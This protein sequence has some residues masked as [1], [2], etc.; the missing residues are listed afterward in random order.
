MPPDP[1]NRHAIESVDP[2]AI[3][4]IDPH[5]IDSLDP[6]AIDSIDRQTPSDTITSG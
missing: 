1:K 2:R 3:D 5:A 6:R 4:S